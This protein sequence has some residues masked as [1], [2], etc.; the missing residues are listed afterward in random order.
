[1]PL[2]GHWKRLQTPLRRTTRR[3]A[4]LIAAAAGFL[5]VTVVIVLY[6]A[7][8]SGSSAA[9]P[10]CIKVTA[11]SSTGGATLHACGQA[12]ARW[13]RSAAVRHDALARSVREECRGAGYR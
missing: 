13:C 9:G 1:M 2:E 3:E 4:R 5:A 8:Q 7:L 10:G 6:V 11:A 12:A